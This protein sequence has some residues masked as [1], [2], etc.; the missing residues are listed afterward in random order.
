MK[1]FL[2]FILILPWLAYLTGIPSLE[3]IYR[4]G[5]NQKG[6]FSFYYKQIFEEKSDIDILFLGP[7]TL[8]TAID[9]TYLTQELSAKLKRPAVVL[10][11][12]N[13][14]QGEDFTDL[15][16]NAILQKRKVKMLVVSIPVKNENR[17]HAYSHR[18]IRFE[19]GTYSDLDFSDKIQVYALSILGMPRHLLN[20][21]RH[22]PVSEIEVNPN[23]GTYKVRSSL[24]G[25]FNPQTSEKQIHFSREQLFKT[26]NHYDSVEPEF[27]KYQFHF[28]NKWL[29]AAA[30]AGIAVVDL[31]TPKFE[32]LNSVHT[33]VAVDW[34]KKGFRNIF[35]AGLPAK[36]VFEGKS[37]ENLK[38]YYYDQAHLNQNGNEYFTR[39]IA[40]AITEFF[41]EN[42]KTR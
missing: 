15:Q 26:E 35:S 5:P 18:W 22:V 21:F 30:D 8:W 1:T 32:E 34:S 14:W 27:S 6:P 38:N 42:V 4:D 23:D 19:P 25:E 31:H 17:G 36:K 11:I 16:L 40:P 10:S 13:N 12:G 20:Y 28:L 9:A 2:A 37:V 39:A 41:V 29:K 33:P 24:S 7:S 3:H